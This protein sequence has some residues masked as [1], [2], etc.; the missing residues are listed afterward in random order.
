MIQRT[1]HTL[2]M[3]L[4]I[5]SALN[6]VIVDLTQQNIQQTVSQGLSVITVTNQTCEFCP[7]A[8]KVIDNLNNRYPDV[9][10]GILSLEN[11]P[12]IAQQVNP[13]QLPIVQVVY[14]GGLRG[15]VNG[16]I[17]ESE[18]VSVIDQALEQDQKEQKL[19]SGEVR[20]TDVYDFT[21]EDLDGNPYT[22]SDFKGL[23]ILDVWATWCGPCKNMI[24]FIVEMHEKYADQGL[25]VIGLSKEAPATVR[26][27]K[28]QM[29][30]SGVEMDYLLLNDPSG[31]ALMR[32][33][34]EAFPTS[35]FIAPDGKL[36]TKKTGFADYMRPELEQMIKANL[37]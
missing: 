22:L 5:A 18:L 27:F 36:L 21:A 7:Q 37:P 29:A 24:P 23:I 16:D 4:F 9:T 15:E 28:E 11:F 30:S 12:Q 34:I 33:G 17:Q 14:N 8:R 25:V 26:Q 1:I 6:A 2:I 32:L 19:L 3:I 10:F 20:F 13:A 35:F 31:D